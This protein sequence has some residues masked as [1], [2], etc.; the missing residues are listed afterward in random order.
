MSGMQHRPPL[1]WAVPV[2]ALLAAVVVAVPVAALS[3]AVSPL[4]LGDAGPLVRWGLVLLKVVHH[5]SASLTIGLLIVAA[6]LVRE[7][8]RTTRRAVAA[9]VASLSALL[10]TLSALGILVLGFGDLAGMPPST[11]GYL[12]QL[13]GNMSLE[14]MSLRGLEVL[15]AALL[16]PF[17][18]VARTRA[19]LAW[20][21]VLALL[22]LAPLA[23]SGHA[24]GSEGHETAV[25]ALGIHLVGVNVWVGG[26]LALALLLPVLGPALGD[27]LRRYST[28][29]TW[30]FAA[31]ALS[32]VLFA[33][34]TVSELSDLVSPYWLVIWLKIAALSGL[35]VFGLLQRRAILA[36]PEG[37]GMFARLALLESL[38]LAAA[39]ALGAVLSRTPP[40]AGRETRV[41]DMA[42][43]LTGY[44]MPPPFTPARLFDTWQTTWIFLLAAL[45]AVGLYTAGVIKLRRRGD[46]WPIWRLLLW[47]AG[48]GVFVWVTSGGPS[49]YGRVMFS[50]HMIMHMMLMMAVPI[51]LVPAQAITL[52]YRTLPARK[53]RTLGPR[54]ILT[55]VVHSRWATFLVNPLVAAVIFFGGL[56]VFYWTALLPWALST[57]VGHVFMVVHFTLTGFTFV[58]SLVGRDPGPPKWQ[59]PMRIIVLLGTLAAHA[60]FGLSL[61][62]G[63]WLLAPEFYKTIDVPW[64]DDLL[65]DQQIGGAIAWGVGEVPTV[66]IVLMVMVDWAR[67]D[68]REGARTDRQAERDGG[69]ELAAYNARLQAMHERSQR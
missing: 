23:F 9:K 27:A 24:S 50:Q 26:L 48:W 51:L 41:G 11:P 56:I 28:I 17:A 34:L 65:R 21:S 7:G 2:A 31:V 10:W 46:R 8:P 54:E 57:H 37:P 22:T 20:A 39:V 52:A 49:V 14:V 25:T 58:W 16:V 30:C 18:A 5:M 19:A 33:Q 45:L 32:G 13:W 40:P 4:A 42:Y 29:A 69:A 12:S 59:G 15:M 38:L 64:V 44:P 36:G 43:V 68:E 62:M 61:M 47:V 6:F 1:T 63:T 67:R 53:D 60:F 66:I 3:G 55:A 35:F